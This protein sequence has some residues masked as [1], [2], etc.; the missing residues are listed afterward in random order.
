M[1]E[2]VVFALRNYDKRL[3]KIEDQVAMISVL[4]FS[5]I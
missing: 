5:L 2:F 4:T 3:L 1:K